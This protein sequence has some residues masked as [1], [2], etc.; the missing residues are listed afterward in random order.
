V[1]FTWVSASEGEK[2]SQVMKGVTD[3]VKAL[4]PAEK[5]VKKL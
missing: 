1:I 2:F 4:G 5:L 3:K